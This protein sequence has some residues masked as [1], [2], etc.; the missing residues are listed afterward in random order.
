MIKTNGATKD[1]VDSEYDSDPKNPCCGTEKCRPLVDHSNLHIQTAPATV[2]GALWMHIPKV[3][4]FLVFSMRLRKITKSNPEFGIRE[5]IP[6]NLLQ[7]SSINP[8]DRKSSV[9][10]KMPDLQPILRVVLSGERATQVKNCRDVHKWLLQ[11]RLKPNITKFPSITKVL[12]NVGEH[13]SRD[14]PKTMVHHYIRA[15]KDRLKVLETPPA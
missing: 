3:L 1:S 4:Q 13:L 6:T 7:L 10:S 15:V 9:L 14:R 5:T 2:V 11:S 8:M 12:L